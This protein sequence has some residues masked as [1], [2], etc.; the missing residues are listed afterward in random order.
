MHTYRDEGQFHGQDI[1]GRKAAGHNSHIH[2]LG[3]AENQVQQVQQEACISLI[4]QQCM[5]VV[6]LSLWI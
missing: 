1:I 4:I 3:K 5:C 2:P 6:C